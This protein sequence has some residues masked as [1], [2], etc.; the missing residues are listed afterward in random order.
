MAGEANTSTFIIIES[1]S[2]VYTGKLELPV[3]LSVLMFH[4]SSNMFVIIQD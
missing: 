3:L 2:L 4:A 1:M